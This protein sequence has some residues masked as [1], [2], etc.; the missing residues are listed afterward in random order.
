MNLSTCD[1]LDVDEYEIKSSICYENEFLPD[2][3]M[4]HGS[5]AV[6][7][8]ECVKCSTSPSGSSSLKSINEKDGKGDNDIP[9]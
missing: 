7:D 1:S 5:R 9:I 8:G 2:E 6:F 3:Y 4:S